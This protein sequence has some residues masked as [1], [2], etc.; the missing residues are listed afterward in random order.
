VLDTE[1]PVI[2]CPGPD[3]TRGST[4][5]VC[6]YEATG[7]EFDPTFSD[8]CPDATISH[9]YGPWSIQTSLDGATFPVGV[10]EVVWT[11]TDASGNSTQCTITITVND[12]ENPVA[13]CIPQMDAV[14]DADGNFQVTIP[15]VELNSTDNCGVVD[16]EIS[17][18]GTNFGDSFL[19][20]CADACSWWSS[21]S[22]TARIRCSG[23]QP[24]L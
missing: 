24:H 10:T 13:G 18:D 9:N 15:M 6:G 5:G 3:F 14:L 19:V 17:R 2:T 23:Q 11:V 8:N 1:L 16:Y 21:N 12:T 7:G 20:N 4:A 22:Y